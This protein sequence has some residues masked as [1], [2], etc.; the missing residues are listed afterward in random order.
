MTEAIHEASYF[1]RDGSERRRCT[2]CPHECR[3]AEGFKGAY[4]VRV[5]H[6]GALTFARIEAGL[7]RQRHSKEAT[8]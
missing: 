8:T 7:I 3:I 1:E 6:R 5:N 2:L 4:G